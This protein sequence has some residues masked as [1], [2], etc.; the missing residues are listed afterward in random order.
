MHALQ[1]LHTFALPCQCHQL[2]TISDGQQLHDIDFSKPFCL[3]GEGS[4][5][6]FVDDFAGTV[7]RIALRGISIE[8]R[9]SDWLIDVA[10]GENWHA[11]VVHLLEKNIAGLENLALIPGT[12]GAA[13]VQNIGAY[14]VELAEFIEYVEGFDIDTKQC[15]R[16][17]NAQCEFGYRDSVFKHARKGRFVIT[18]VGLSLNKHWQPK[19]SYAPLQ[20]LRD[21]QPTAKQVCETVINI[22]QSKLPDPNVLA[23]AGSFFKNPIV[24][25]EAV[26]KLKQRFTT[27]PVYYVDPHQQKIAAGWLIEQLGLKGHQIGDIAVYQH[28]ALVLV[29][30]GQGTSDDLISMI[31]YIQQH[32]WRQFSVRL[33][34]EVRLMGQ[35]DEIHIQGVR[36]E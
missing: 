22:R 34:H 9:D 24:S 3:L 29:N 35:H 33:E 14:G 27:M 4:N 17:D 1:S 7:I 31:E 20:V 19:L 8:E 10:A 2:V 25:N 30:L 11:L 13:P 32:V 6:I 21:R 28:Q 18:Q 15:V 23:N 26:A 5:T 16:L 12:V 36:N